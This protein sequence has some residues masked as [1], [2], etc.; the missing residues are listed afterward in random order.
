MTLFRELVRQLTADLHEQPETF[1]PV[2]LARHLDYDR[3]RED[4]EPEMRSMVRDAAGDLLGES[5]IEARA[6]SELNELLDNPEDLRAVFGED[7]ERY[8]D[9]DAAAED[10]AQ[11]DEWERVPG[12]H[13]RLARIIRHFD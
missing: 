6:Q 10:A 3:L 12:I 7:L 5:L 4:L 8:I 13:E 11:T 9:T 1:D 2:W